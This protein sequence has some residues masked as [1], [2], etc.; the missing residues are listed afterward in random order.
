MKIAVDINKERLEAIE[1][2]LHD[3][4]GN[5]T[6]ALNELGASDSK[7]DRRKYAAYWMTLAE[8]TTK[9]RIAANELKMIKVMPGDELDRLFPAIEVTTIPELCHS[10]MVK[11]YEDLGLIHLRVMIYGFVKGVTDMEEYYNRTPLTTD[12]PIDHIKMPFLHIF[13]IPG[14]IDLTVS[15]VPLYKEGGEK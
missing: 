12:R 2:Y 7:K 8:L 5:F 11:Y 15:T 10:E 3:T 4:C 1:Q 13:F 6:T 14:N 9:A